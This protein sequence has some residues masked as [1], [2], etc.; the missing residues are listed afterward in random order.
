MAGGY[1]RRRGLAVFRA[2]GNRICHDPDLSGQPGD[3]LRN[4]A[5]DPD[6]RFRDIGELKSAIANAKQPIF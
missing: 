2:L 5:E 3:P 6:R 1:E 4:P